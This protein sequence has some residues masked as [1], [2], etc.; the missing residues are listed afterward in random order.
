MS[1]GAAQPGQA[2]FGV[3]LILCLTQRGRRVGRGAPCPDLHCL[4]AARGADLTTEADSGYTPMDLAVALGHKKGKC[5]LCAWQGALPSLPGK[6]PGNSQLPALLGAFFDLPP[7][8]PSLPCRENR[9]REIKTGLVPFAPPP[10]Q[11][12]AG[13]RA[14]PGRMG[15]GPWRKGFSR[16]PLENGRKM[17]TGSCPQRYWLLTG[18][19]SLGFTSLP[20][21]SP[22]GYR[23]SHPQAISE[24]GGGVTRR[25]VL[26]CCSTSA[27]PGRRR[28]LLWDQRRPEMGSGAMP[29]A[30]STG[31]RLGT[32][33]PRWVCASPGGWRGHGASRP[34]TLIPQGSCISALS[35]LGCFTRACIQVLHCWK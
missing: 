2:P 10:N 7:Q 31:R 24:K 30:R 34:G 27:S 11:R 35:R 12:C 26:R 22:T 33:C 8:L 15:T 3:P 19:A 1:R 13:D 14:G 18:L 6:L 23:K 25:L 32:A 29:Q 5:P 20:S 4:L 28:A 17:V 16:L 9:A 21:V